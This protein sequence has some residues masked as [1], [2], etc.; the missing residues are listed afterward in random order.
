MTRI[1]IGF[2]ASF[3]PWLKAIKAA[4]RRWRFLNIKVIFRAGPEL[5]QK[6]I[7]CINTAPPAK[8]NKGETTIAIKTFANP[9]QRMTPGPAIANAAPTRAPINPCVSLTGIPR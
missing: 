5:K 3:R 4:E 6:L 9:A 1:P 2:W 8:P 7:I